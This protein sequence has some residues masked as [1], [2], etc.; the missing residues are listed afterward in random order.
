[1]K[2]TGVD[3]PVA[4]DAVDVA[5]T[6]ALVGT[7]PPEP[8]AAAMLAEVAARSIGELMLL[9]AAALDELSAR[10]SVRAVQEAQTWRA[11]FVGALTVLLFVRL[12]SVLTW[13]GIHPSD[14]TL[15][16]VGAVV[17]FVGAFVTAHLL[18]AAYSAG[19]R[20]VPPTLERFVDGLLPFLVAVMSLFA[21]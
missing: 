15:K 20:T 7:P 19:G 13:L 4:S 16:A 6:Q 17:V 8:R 3:A 12:A 2:K 11:L 21:H 10:R 14:T 18:L 5:R 1:L 9:P